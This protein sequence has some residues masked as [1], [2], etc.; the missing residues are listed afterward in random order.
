[1]HRK[2]LFATWQPFC[3]RGDKIT[4][5][6]WQQGAKL[7]GNPLWVS[8]VLWHRGSLPTLVDI[9]DQAMPRTDVDWHQFYRL[10]TLSLKK[11]DLEMSTKC[12]PL[13]LSLDMLM[14]NVDLLSMFWQTI[15]NQVQNQ[16]SN[17]FD[18]QISLTTSYKSTTPQPQHWNDKP[19]NVIT[20]TTSKLT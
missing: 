18:Q 7:T 6:P 10:I 16:L 14:N 4:L 8:D 2:I 1:M 13:H 19:W 11:V 20:S 3:P 17:I 15:S 5:M 9:I 12:Q